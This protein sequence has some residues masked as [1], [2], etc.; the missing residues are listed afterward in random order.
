MRRRAEDTVLAVTPQS[1]DEAFYAGPHA[2]ILEVNCG[3]LLERSCGR[4]RSCD[5]GTILLERNCGRERSCDTGTIL[6]ER[7][8]GGKD[9][10]IRERS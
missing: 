5:T 2:S 9:Y 4:E 1:R 6:L 3:R 8:C 10:A 7:N